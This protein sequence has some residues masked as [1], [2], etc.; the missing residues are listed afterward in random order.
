MHGMIGERYKVIKLV[1]CGGM[2]DVFLAQDLRD[3]RRVALKVLR[4]L[5]PPPASCLALWHRDAEAVAELRHP[6]IAQVYA[7]S[8]P[9]E[10]PAY[11]AS[12]YFDGGSVN[13]IL[14]TRHPVSPWAI[15]TIAY[16]I[17]AALQQAHRQGVIH[18]DLKPSNVLL[19]ARGRIALTDFGGTKAYRDRMIL[20]RGV[21][22][23][24]PRFGTLAFMSPEQIRGEVA[25]PASD[26]FALG[27]LLYALATQASP[28][29]EKDPRD[30]MRRI[31]QV[32]Y[33]PLVQRRPRVPT[34]LRVL[35][36]DCLQQR[37]EA[38]PPAGVVA[39]RLRELLGKPND[40]EMR[41]VV[42][43]LMQRPAG[44]SST[45]WPWVPAMNKPRPAAAPSPGAK[46]NRKPRITVPLNEFD[47]RHE[48]GSASWSQKVVQSVRTMARSRTVVGGR[49]P[50]LAS[51]VLMLGAA[52]VWWWTGAGAPTESREGSAERV[53]VQ[54]HTEA[55]APAPAQGDN[56]WQETPRISD[57]AK[58]APATFPMVKRAVRDRPKPSL[59]MLDSSTKGAVEGN[60]NNP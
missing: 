12:E 44:A 35:V 11:V 42:R 16:A 8:G 50:V 5:E 52:G 34:A 17:V 40:E 37:A 60:S 4:D 48:V 46:P 54:A 43:D 51:V 33:V 25:T 10:T 27:C 55:P 57:T 39:D 36:T 29:A 7:H 1:G 41:L 30:T 56:W 53:V 59:K 24:S 9:A 32:R 31:E 47:A 14:A 15:S 58:P 22:H 26:M 2:A 38:R 13:E 21:R 20:R 23:L 28:F 18:R 6:T 3:N 45:H 19:D 49:W